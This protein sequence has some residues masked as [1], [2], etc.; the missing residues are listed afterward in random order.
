[1][2][3]GERYILNDDGEPMLESDLLTWGRW[4]EGG[5]R[6]VAHDTIGDVQVSTVFLGHDHAFGGA[7]PVLWE[8]M[9]F[10][11]AHDGFQDRYTSKDDALAGHAKAVELVKAAR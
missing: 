2:G 7:V 5:G 4:M 10:G 9:I 3:M 1:M 8:T 6:R 11:G